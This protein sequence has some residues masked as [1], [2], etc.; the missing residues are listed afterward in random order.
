MEILVEIRT[1]AMLPECQLAPMLGAGPFGRL[2]FAALLHQRREQGRS[3]SQRQNSA[4][5]VILD[6]PGRLP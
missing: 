2:R 1:I 6:T 5:A 3:E 4:N